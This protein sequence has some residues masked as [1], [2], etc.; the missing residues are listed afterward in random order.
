[1]RKVGL[2]FNFYSGS[3]FFSRL[4][5]QVISVPF[6]VWINTTAAPRQLCCLMKVSLRGFYWSTFRCLT[7]LANKDCVSSKARTLWAVKG[8]QKKKLSI[9]QS[10]EGNKDVQVKD[11]RE[12]HKFGTE[13]LLNNSNE[14]GGKKKIQYL[15]QVVHNSGC[16]K[17]ITNFKKFSLSQKFELTPNFV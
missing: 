7:G 17:R 11:Q 15:F 6:V 1:M 12:L 4:V 14:S 3:D 5:R 16:W 9:I 10:T 2:E 13:S 8:K